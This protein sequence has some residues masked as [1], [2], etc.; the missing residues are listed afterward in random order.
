MVRFKHDDGTEGILIGPSNPTFHI[1]TWC[2]DP[3]GQIPEQVHLIMEPAPGMKVL[4][5]F[6]GPETLTKLID[7]LT[8]HKA[9][10]WPTGQ[11]GG[12][13]R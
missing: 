10:V 7:A 2:S 9:D 11:E 1:A 6:T 5:R 4:F 13:A 12:T 3:H 8:D